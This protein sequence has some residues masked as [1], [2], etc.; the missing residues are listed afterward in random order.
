MSRSSTSAI[1]S[2]IGP[3]GAP[4]L[5]NWGCSHRPDRRGVKGVE[6]LLKVMEIVGREEMNRVGR[7]DVWNPG[8]LIPEH[9]CLTFPEHPFDH[10]RLVQNGYVY[11]S[12]PCLPAYAR[13][14]SR[15]QFETQRRRN[16]PRRWNLCNRQ[17]NLPTQPN[18]T[19]RPRTRE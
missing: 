16:N 15:A 1:L 4:K 12:P 8:T 3:Y 14:P 9:Q 7:K 17:P 2:Y 19:A 5:D 10:G 13:Q 6:E 18:T 11:A